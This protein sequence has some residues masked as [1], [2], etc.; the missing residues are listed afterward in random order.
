MSLLIIWLTLLRT[1]ISVVPS[2]PP[3]NQC[4]SVDCH[5]STSLSFFNSLFTLLPL[6]ISILT[7]FHARNHRSHCCCGTLWF[8]YLYCGIFIFPSYCQPGSCTGA[9]GS[10]TYSSGS[11]A[12]H[13][14]WFPG[15]SS[16]LYSLI[17][18]DPTLLQPF[19]TPRHLLKQWLKTTGSS[20]PRAV[21]RW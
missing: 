3:V 19:Q 15:T 7:N 11:T 4:I 17:A 9:C 6:L 2:H 16:S 14:F 5:L 18:K 8:F 20:P 13:T 10:R 12:Y 1:C 21:W